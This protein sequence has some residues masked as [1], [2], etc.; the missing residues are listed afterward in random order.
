MSKRYP[1]EIKAFIAANVQG[2]TIK[3]IA[4][5]VS[6]EFGI[7]FTEAQV[8]AFKKNHRLKSGTRG[9]IK[10]G[11]PT[12][13]YPAEVKAFIEGNYVGVS[14][15]EMTKRLNK[16]FGTN[17]TYKQ[18]RAYY[19]NHRYHSGIIVRFQKGHVPFNRR[20]K[21]E[22]FSPATE[23]K[24]GQMPVNYLPVGTEKVKDDGYVWVKLA[25]PRTWK[26]K[27]RVIWE[28]THGPVPDGHVLLFVDGNKLNITLDNLLLISRRQLAIINNKQLIS[29]DPE[30]TKTGLIVADVY[31]KITDRR[32]KKKVAK[33]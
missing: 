4:A 31:L 2:R 23:F 7:Q 19:R 30:A 17:Y 21:G 26:Q 27:H 11:L 18:I 5:L 20:K 6:A 1:A 10:P 13:L 12:K 32:R 3:E 9:G 25:D 15:M 22:H 14:P 24:P 28:E 16:T 33:P 8:T 29:C